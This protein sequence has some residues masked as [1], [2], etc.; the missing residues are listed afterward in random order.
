[1]KSYSRFVAFE[2][3]ICDVVENSEE[4]IVRKE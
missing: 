1:M 2:D 3:I 4:E